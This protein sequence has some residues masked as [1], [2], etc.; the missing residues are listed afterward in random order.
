MLARLEKA[1]GSNAT[2]MYI[3]GADHN[4]IFQRGGDALYERLKGF[5]DGLAAVSPTT[6]PG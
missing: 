2:H 4:D 6:R 3:D 5:V 1:A